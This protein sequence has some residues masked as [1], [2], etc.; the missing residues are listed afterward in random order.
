MRAGTGRVGY[1][2][3]ILQLAVR[4]M[5]F[6]AAELGDLTPVFRRLPLVA[7]AAIAVIASG[8]V[9][10][11]DDRCAVPLADWQPREALV[12]KLRQAGWTV[13]RIRADDGCY[14]VMATDRDGRPVKARFDPAT[15]ERVEGGGHGEHDDH[16]RH[17]HGHD[18]DR[19]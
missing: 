4:S 12:E 2:A 16:G 8:P 14:K 18:G 13:I 9:V 7:L 6:P 11:A 17:G 10:R 5:C 15:L 3:R 1:F 19:D